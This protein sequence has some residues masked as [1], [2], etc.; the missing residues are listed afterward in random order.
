MKIR[1]GGK[2]HWGGKR[3]FLGCMAMATPLPNITIQ[4]KDTH[5]CDQFK[6]VFICGKKNTLFVAQGT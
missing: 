4:I 5:I 2:S 1:E 6:V 3:K